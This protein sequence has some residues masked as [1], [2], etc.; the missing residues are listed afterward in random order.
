MS[1]PEFFPLLSAVPPGEAA[2]FRRALGTR[3]V[4]T[5]GSG[6]L[7]PARHPEHARWI[8]DES[9][10]HRPPHREV[11]ILLSGELIF[12]VAGKPYRLTPG[13]IV[14]FDHDESRD[15]VSPPHRPPYR[16]LWLHFCGRQAVTFNTVERLPCGR[17][18]REVTTRVRAGAPLL[19]ESW[20]RCRADT[21]EAEWHW[22]LLCSLTLSMIL[23]ILATTRPIAP[24]QQARQAVLAVQEHIRHHLNGDLRLEALADFAGYS[25]YF[26]H[27]IFKRETGET[28]KSFIDRLRLEHAQQGLRANRTLEA[29]ADSI[30][31][32]SASYFNRFFRK[33]TGM[34]PGQWRALAGKP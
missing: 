3:W 6:S 18:I 30:G 31:M 14:F 27:R 4:A 32:E 34:T 9:H 25:P 13:T 1:S 12:G 24:Q 11:L 33:Q 22:K 7:R 10:V 21:Q 2:A 20:D 29:V 28:L 15:W 5:R 19:M 16:A 8:A 23:E 26:F 17:S